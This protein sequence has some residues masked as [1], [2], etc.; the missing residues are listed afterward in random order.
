MGRAA[1]GSTLP[2]EIDRMPRTLTDDEIDSL[3]AES[4]SLKKGWT[5]R[6][7]PLTKSN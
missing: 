6:L 3:V 5:K 1:G 4:K 2:R 7:R